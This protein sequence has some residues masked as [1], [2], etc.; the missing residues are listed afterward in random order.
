MLAVFIACGSANPVQAGSL[1][2]FIYGGDQIN[3]IPGTDVTALKTNANYLAGRYTSFETLSEYIEGAA[4]TTGLVN[5]GSAI[6]GWLEAPQTGTNYYFWIASTDSSEFWLSTDATPGKASLIASVAGKTGPREY[7]KFTT[8]KSAPISLARGSKYYFQILQKAGGSGDG[9]VSIGWQLPDGVLQRPISTVYAQNYT[10][11]AIAPVITV[12]LYDTNVVEGATIIL[13]VGV[14]A[15]QPVAYQWSQGT[16]DIPNEILSSLTRKV[17]LSDNGKKFTVKITNPLGSTNSTATLNVIA[18]TTPPTLNSANPKGNPFKVTVVF[19]KE[20]DPS[21]ATNTANYSIGASDS[22]ATPIT[23][24][25]MEG[26]DTVVLSTAL[27]QGKLYTLTV[28]NVRD[29]TAARN[30]VAAN[31]RASFVLTDGAVQVRFFNT[32][33]TNGIGRITDITGNLA[34]LDGPVDRTF[35][36]TSFETPTWDN[37]SNYLGQIQGYVVAPENGEYTFAISSSDSSLLYFSMDENPANKTLLATV[38]NT[39]TG[40][41]EFTKTTEQ[42]SSPVSLVGGSRYYLEA[43]FKKNGIGGGVSVAWQKPGGELIQSNSPAIPPDYISAIKKTGVVKITNQPPAS[44]TAIE[45]GSAV[46]TIGPDGVDGSPLY[47]YQW[48]KNGKAVE[49]AT[50]PTYATPPI[51]AADNGAAYSLVVSNIFSATTSSNCVLHV[52]A[53]VTPP[54]VLGV[55]SIKPPLFSVGF[56]E[57]VNAASATNTTNY[58]LK[59]SSGAVVA[60][61]SAVLSAKGDSV[62]L[63][64][65]SLT[66][67]ASYNVTI[68]GVKDGSSRANSMATTNIV[69]VPLDLTVE[70]INN[71][72]DFSVGLSGNKLNILAGGAGT[73]GQADQFVYAFMAV[74]NDFDFRLKVESLSPTANWAQCGLMAR[75]TVAPGSRFFY[76]AVASRNGRNVYW[77]QWRE[78]TDDTT[79]SDATTRPP[80]PLPNAWVRLVRDGAVF[81]YFRSADGVNW[82]LYE[83]IDSS[84]SIYGPM[85][86]TILIGIATTS[87]NTAG[88]VDAIAGN[89]EALAELP[90]KIVT[91]PPTAL[92]AFTYHRLAITVGA[93]GSHLKYQWRKDGADILDATESSYRVDRATMAD[94]GAYSVR[95]YNRINEIISSNCV[96]TVTEDTVPPTIYAVKG[97][98]S[99]DRVTISF[100]E[101]VDG[102]NGIVTGNYQIQPDL[103]ITGATLENETNVVLT[104]SRQ[105]PATIYTVSVTG[106][107]DLAQNT[108]AAGA[109]KQF[110]AYSLAP[111]FAVM[112]L[113]YNVAIG[114]T[115]AD[116]TASEKFI[117]NKPDSV[118]ARPDFSSPWNSG[119]EYAGRLSAMLTAPETGDYRFYISSDSQSL[120]YVSTDDQPVDLAM[121]S[122]TAQVSAATGW[123]AEGQWDKGFEQGSEPMSL[124]EGQKYYIYA[125]WKPGAGPSDGCSVGWLRPTLTNEIVVIPGQFLSSYVNPDGVSV[126]ISNQPQNVTVLAN[127]AATFSI[128][129]QGIWELGS[130]AY[131]WQRDRTNIAGATGAT[132]TTPLT[133]L[134]DNGAKFRCLV[135]VPGQSK[136]SDEATLTVLPNDGPAPKI[137]SIVRN[138]SNITLTWTSGM[139]QSADAVTGAY[140]DVAGA[141]S[142]YTFPAAGAKKFFR[143]RGSVVVATAKIDKIS[144]TGSNVTIA[145]TGGVLQASDAVTGAYADVAGA[146]SPYTAQASGTRRF[147]RVRSN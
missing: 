98:A 35:F 44:V 16:T 52:D 140:L 119:T 62:T 72:Q 107:T 69:F 95:V 127:N 111:G 58:V 145:W 32:T 85:P 97:S 21:S 82:V 15:S 31:S 146:A 138:G 135:S 5:Y 125:L 46:L 110:T 23:A 43:L 102:T 129:A 67:G 8:Q 133:T 61:A 34:L 51:V 132:Y 136:T 6:K 66:S 7:A 134:A 73:G 29:T 60:I 71:S 70:N 37:G 42:V 20:V 25:R 124:V 74:T 116:F 40:Q 38:N 113:F 19:S 101:R 11:A 80:A 108:I 53:D 88:T 4:T 147:Y 39:A 65:A 104:T 33:T 105:I 114:D 12:P 143:V 93:E 49:G 22:S 9:N 89:I 24:A 99:F 17:K 63:S 10:N 96:V 78:G 84:A 103:A 27:S 55:G 76:N 28:N 112:E 142:P 123:T 106:V 26:L 130:A 59:T 1:I 94:G 30:M 47:F 118:S 54:T 139:L 77:P 14:D 91:Q 75:S 122:P 90:V 83:K 13:A 86:D 18:D 45:G 48:L 81:S 131:Q 92:A 64:A 3:D 115:L 41:R 121:G 128:V 50:A 141:A 87:Q 56:S 68:A 109:S 2:R 57:A 100:D 36:N 120:L 144:R 79:A 117:A 126:T 137:D